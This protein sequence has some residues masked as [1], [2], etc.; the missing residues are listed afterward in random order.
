MWLDQVRTLALVKRRIGDLQETVSRD[1]D[2]A[3]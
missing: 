3:H 2:A 1:L